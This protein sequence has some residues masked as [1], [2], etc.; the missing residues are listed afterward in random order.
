[1]QSASHKQTEPSPRQIHFRS[2]LHRSVDRLLSV[3]RLSGAYAAHSKSLIREGSMN[4]SG[5]SAEDV[6]GMSSE[7]L[8]SVAAVK[9]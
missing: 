5:N 8:I 1:M 3:I 4:G 7:G 6:E 2:A 9:A